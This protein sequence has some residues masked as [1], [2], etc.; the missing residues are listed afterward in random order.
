[1][2]YLERKCTPPTL[3]AQVR[4]IKFFLRSLPTFC[5]HF[6]CKSLT[7]WTEDIYGKAQSWL[8]CHVPSCVNPRATS[9]EKEVMVTLSFVR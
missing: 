6:M 8:T 1:M 5:A 7:R 3:D 9:G 4:L 2:N